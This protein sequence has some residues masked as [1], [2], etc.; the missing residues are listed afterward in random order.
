MPRAANIQE[1]KLKE[2]TEYTHNVLCS[3]II[4]RHNPKLHSFYKNIVFPAEAGYFYFSG[5]FKRLSNFGA[6][7]Q[8]LKLDIHSFFYKNIFYK[9]TEAEICEIL[10][11]FF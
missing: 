2:D 1:E 8:V 3:L 4:S 9:N 5:D 11:I 10:R 7:L 6:S